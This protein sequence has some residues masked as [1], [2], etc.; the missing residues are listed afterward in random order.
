MLGCDP[1]RGRCAAANTADTCSPC[2]SA[3][4]DSTVPKPSAMPGAERGGDD[5]ACNDDAGSSLRGE[6]ADAVGALTCPEHA[7]SCLCQEFK[8]GDALVGRHLRLQPLRQIC[9]VDL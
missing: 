1:S 5:T 7:K 8:E 2:E 9:E 6:V 4:L 3:A